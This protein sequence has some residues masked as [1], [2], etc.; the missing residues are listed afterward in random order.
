MSYR[1]RLGVCRVCNRPFTY[2][3]SHRR[4]R[5]QA[6]GAEASAEWAEQ[7]AA[8]EGPAFDRWREACVNFWAPGREDS[9]AE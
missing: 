6:C 7:L 2:K 5:C 4:D 3:D 1:L 8:R 9:P